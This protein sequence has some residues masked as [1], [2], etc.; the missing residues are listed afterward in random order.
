[1]SLSEERQRQSFSLSVIVPALN[2]EENIEPAVLLIKDTLGVCPR[3]SAFEI[4]VVNDGSSDKTGEI[5]RGL[6]HRYNNILYLE[7]EVNRS[8]G[9][10]Y[11]RG[12]SYARYDYVTWLAADGSY[13]KEELLKYLD[14]FRFDRISISYSYTKEALRT[15]SLIR[16]AISRAYRMFISLVFGIRG[17]NYIN[18]MALYKREFLKSIPIRA[19]GFG[20]MAELV[21]RAWK[22][23]YTF[24]NVAMNSIERN[25]G[26]TKLFKL[27]NVKDLLRTLAL[28]FWEFNVQ[29]FKRR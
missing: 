27:N 3:I 1:M 20:I 13:I 26:K 15:R 19:N 21:L 5:A 8:I 14:A 29:R 18:G 10:C 4:I 22:Q 9:Y 25:K 12:L 11:K 16:R 2:E 17:I 23:N 7:N 24:Q 28:L 6:S